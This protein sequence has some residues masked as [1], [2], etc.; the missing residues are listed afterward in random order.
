MPKF[1][2]AF[3]GLKKDK[4]LTKEELV[5]AIRFMIAAE[6][7]AVQLYNQLSE[8]IDNELAIKV[9]NDIADEEKVHA[10]E[11]LK[12]LEIL[13]PKEI[14]FY[15][16]GKEEVKE[17]KFS[18]TNQA[19][20]YL[21]DITNEKIIIAKNDDLDFVYKIAKENNL[22]L[23]GD[24]IAYFIYGSKDGDNPYAEGFYK[25]RYIDDKK[26]ESK[27]FEESSKTL[28]GYE[29]KI[30]AAIEDKNKDE[31]KEIMEDINEEVQELIDE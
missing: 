13:D 22:D 5:R 29:N 23:A 10:G 28:L 15:E 20:Q 31:L 27:I 18:S 24:A 17:L 7:E 1:E 8:S 4:K 14:D 9:L 19:I 2:D 6:Y 3:S 21:S 26:K 16:E 30:S 25:L 11:F 12:L